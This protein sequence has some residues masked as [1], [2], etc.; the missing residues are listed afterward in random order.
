MKNKQ[1]T[2]TG[3]AQ[4]HLRFPTELKRQ[5]KNYAEEENISETAVITLALQK[6]FTSDISD[7]SLLIA[8]MSSADSKLHKLTAKIDLGHKLMMDFFQYNFIFFPPLPED[9]KQLK[10]KYAAAAQ[11]FRQFMLMLRRRLKTMP[12][13]EETIFGDMAE[14]YEAEN[15]AR[16]GNS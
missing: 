15:P 12:S 9:T 10:I 1:N 2:K 16:K 14:K 4:F 13:L 11:G 8:K 5:I 6:F 7:E 3:N